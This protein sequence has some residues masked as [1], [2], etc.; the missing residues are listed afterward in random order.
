MRQRNG[1]DLSGY[2]PDSEQRPISLCGVAI[3]GF[4]MVVAMLA[5]LGL[6]IAGHHA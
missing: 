3:Y 5:V 2:D 6:F 1:S 4:V